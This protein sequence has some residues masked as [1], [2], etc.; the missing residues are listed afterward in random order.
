MERVVEAMLRSKFGAS[1]LIG[2]VLS[3]A[4][5]FVFDILGSYAN[6]ELWMALALLLLLSGM[7]LIALGQE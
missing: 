5:G 3:C 4:A 6:F 2:A 7:V 1:L